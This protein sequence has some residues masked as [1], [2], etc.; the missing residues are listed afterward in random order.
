[1]AGPVAY[2]VVTPEYNHSFP[3]PLKNLID[4]YRTEWQAGAERRG[5]IRRGAAGAPC[6]AR[7]LCR[8]DCCADVTTTIRQ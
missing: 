1:M 7:P 5:R 8:Y 2:V 4:L 6:A 3:A